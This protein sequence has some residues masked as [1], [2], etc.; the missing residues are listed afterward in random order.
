MIADY[1]SF[2]GALIVLIFF[3]AVYR[4]LMMIKQKNI[5]SIY[6]RKTKW[7]GITDRGKAVAG[8]GQPL[9]TMIGRNRA[10]FVASP[11]FTQVS[12]TCATFL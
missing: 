3:L 1:I 8:G 7:G 10:T 5:I 12:T 4:A 11:A 9:M 6:M 2:V